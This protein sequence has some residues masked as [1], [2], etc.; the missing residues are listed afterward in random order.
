MLGPRRAGA[1]RWHRPEALLG[2]GVLAIGY[3]GTVA[4]IAG[5][6]ESARLEMVK[7][8]PAPRTYRFERSFETTCPPRGYKWVQPHR[9]RPLIVEPVWSPYPTPRTLGLA[10]GTPPMRLIRYTN[11][12]PGYLGLSLGL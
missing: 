8:A 9:P 7:P 2:L 4:L 11:D 3:W 12:Q 1:S 10:Y 5:Q 6:R